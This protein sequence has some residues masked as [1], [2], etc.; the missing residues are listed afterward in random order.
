MKRSKTA[1]AVAAI[2]KAA[3]KKMSA[4]EKVA[5]LRAR[6][7]KAAARRYVDGFMSGYLLGRND[8]AY[9]ATR[10]V[11]GIEAIAERGAK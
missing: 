10:T 1:T 8:G 3:R 9:G 2:D 4:R 11:E 7:R 6:A 5:S